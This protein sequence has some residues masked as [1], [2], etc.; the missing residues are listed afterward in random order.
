MHAFHALHSEDPIGTSL[1]GPAGEQ[2]PFLSDSMVPETPVRSSRGAFSANSTSN[3]MSLTPAAPDAP[4]K[5]RKRKHDENQPP[6]DLYTVPSYQDLTPIPPGYTYVQSYPTIHAPFPF[7]L[8]AQP[9]DDTVLPT[10]S[11]DTTS[12]GPTRPCKRKYH[13]EAEKVGMLLRFLRKEL[14]WTLGELLHA[15]FDFGDHVHREENHAGAVSSFLQGTMKT[16]PADIINL[17]MRHPDGRVAETH[18]EYPKLYSAHSDAAA[19]ASNVRVALTCFAVKIVKEKVAREA[20]QAVKPES[21]LH[22]RRRKKDSDGTALAT[23]QWADIGAAT[24]PRVA[25]I[26]ATQQPVLRAL[27]LAVAERGQSVGINGA[28][29]TRKHRPADL[30]CP[31]TL[32]AV[33]YSHRPRL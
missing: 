32:P 5:S 31:C 22:S 10:P 20:E 33:V 27:L 18:V 17:W 3:A 14:G 23:I 29:V 28:T 8:G 16:T 21:G 2:T 24:M 25:N 15:L 26:I 30:V 1:G 9:P 4:R 13:R 6:D 7:L 19:N 12:T 11:F